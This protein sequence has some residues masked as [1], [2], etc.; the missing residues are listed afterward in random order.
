MTAAE[1]KAL[2][3]KRAVA[4]EAMKALHKKVEGEK[5]DLNAEEQKQWDKI[6]DDVDKLG[7]QID[8][9]ESESRAADRNKAIEARQREIEASAGRPSTRAVRQAED[10]AHGRHDRDTKATDD[11]ELRSRYS[12]YLTGDLPAS[13]V[14]ALQADLPTTGGYLVAPV[15]FQ[16]ELI[17]FVDNATFM[18]QLGRVITLT[19]ADSIMFPS[20]DADPADPTWTAEIGTGSEDSTTAVGNRSLTPRPIAER[21]KVSNT[22]IRKSAIPID[23][24]VQ[25][26]LG[27]KAGIT[28]ENAF[29]NGNG[30][31]EPLGVFTASANGIPTTQ[32]T[33]TDNTTTA[34]TADGLINAKYALKGQYQE[35]GSWIFS[36]T[37][38][39]NIRKLKD[40]EGQYLW[41]PGLAGDMGAR[42]TIL[43]RPVYMSEYVPTTFT[44]GLY[45][46]IFGDFSNYWIVD[47][48]TVSVRVISELYAETDQTGFIL[49]AESDG[50]PVLAEAFTRVTL[51]P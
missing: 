19:G 9:A 6:N 31:Q 47:A 40:G 39:R 49:R 26:R 4:V 21:I 27:Y 24:L 34:I 12:Q 10:T 38:V 33:A 20:W 28:M 41:Q 3:D 14:R 13:E 16:N 17:K 1:I 11:R 8:A 22:L 7:E 50:M 46:G 29:L 42:E 15:S 23:R 35:R 5:R 37:A 44:A 51:A 43:G 32:D 2:R 48:L 36:R 30:A 45:V 25:E 18:R